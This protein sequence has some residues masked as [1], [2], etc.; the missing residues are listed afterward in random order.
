MNQNKTN[1]FAELYSLIYKSSL[2]ALEEMRPER[3]I[4]QSEQEYEASPAVQAF[5]RRHNRL[6]KNLIAI[7]RL[8]SQKESVRTAAAALIFKHLPKNGDA[9]L[10]LFQQGCDLSSAGRFKRSMNITDRNFDDCLWYFGD[11][12]NHSTSGFATF[13]NSLPPL[14]SQEQTLA[15]SVADH[16]VL[17]K[18]DAVGHSP[19]PSSLGLPPG[20]SALERA[21]VA[22]D[23]GARNIRLARTMD[24]VKADVKAGRFCADI[25]PTNTNK[26]YKEAFQ[27]AGK[28]LWQA[29]SRDSGSP[30]FGRVV[31]LSIITRSLEALAAAMSTEQGFIALETNT[32]ELVRAFAKPSTAQSAMNVILAGSR[33]L[34]KVEQKLNAIEHALASTAWG[35]NHSVAM[36]YAL[37]VLQAGALAQLSD[38]EPDNKSVQTLTESI[39]TSVYAD[40]RQ[41]LLDLD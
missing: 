31:L 11:L 24:K 26:Q 41:P 27:A 25:V 22:R 9:V 38:R 8:A 40:M 37:E 23:V 29:F 6:Y 10:A 17:S 20:L 5:Q 18:L 13:C 28:V 35:G 16:R 19:D 1:P 3:T 7:N 12:N 34:D 21:I 33:S 2:E 30:L 14:S 32:P 39:A 15:G 36:S 4:E